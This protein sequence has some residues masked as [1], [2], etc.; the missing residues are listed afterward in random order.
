MYNY[1]KVNETKD[2]KNV[3]AIVRKKIMVIEESEQPEIS[4]FD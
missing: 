3:N 2:L 1:L 4:V